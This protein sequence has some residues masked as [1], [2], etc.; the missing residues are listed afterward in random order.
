MSDI[1]NVGVFLS[2]RDGGSMY[3]TSCGKQVNEGAKFCV[4]CGAPVL[5]QPAPQAQVV[6][7]PAPQAQVTAQPAQQVQVTPSQVQ[8]AQMAPQPMQQTQPFV[9]QAVI[10]QQPGTEP[11]TIESQNGMRTELFLACQGAPDQAV[12]SVENVLRANGFKLKDYKGE[13]V[14]KK[15][16]GMMTAMQYVKVTPYGNGLGVQAWVQ[17]GVG[18]IGLKEM[19]LDG[20]VAVVPKK[21]LLKVID[22]MRQAI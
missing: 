10:M 11:R 4:W 16:I 2:Q 14:W 9:Q 13:S 21:M 20:V 17:A 6:P 19:C 12:L 8:Q 18:D 1:V 15:G 3:C 5:A 22:K 7:Q